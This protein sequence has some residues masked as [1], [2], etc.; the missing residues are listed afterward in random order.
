MVRHRLSDERIRAALAAARGNVTVAA[1]DLG[2]ARNSFYKRIAHMKHELHAERALRRGVVHRHSYATSHSGDSGR[3]RESVQNSESAIFSNREGVRTFVPVRN[4]SAA[5]PPKPH[6][7]DVRIAKYLRRDRAEKLARA[8]RRL[9]AALDSD[10]T[11]SSL[12]ERLI[13]DELENWIAKQLPPRKPP[14]D[15]EN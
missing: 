8:R 14:A 6:A 10:I 9:A 12:I 4:T 5:R 11:D 7:S 13:D 2:I 1:R 15:R 3:T